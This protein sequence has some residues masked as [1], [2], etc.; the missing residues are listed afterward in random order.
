ML[1]AFSVAGAL[2]PLGIEITPEHPLLLFQAPELRGQDIGPY[3]ATLVQ[4][5]ADLDPALKAY[6][7]LRV[8]PFSETGATEERV[9]ALLAALQEA[10]VPVALEI[11][12][13]GAGPTAGLKAVEK[14]VADFTVVRGLVVQGLTFDEY[15]PVGEAIR[16]EVAPKVAWLTG[17]IDV[18]ARYGRFISI[19][20]EGLHWTRVMANDWCKPL[21]DKIAACAD[22]VIPVAVYRNGHTIAGVSSALGL[23]TEGAVK[24]WGVEAQSKWYAD[25]GFVEPGVFGV[26]EGQPVAPPSALYRAMILNGAMTGATVYS[27]APWT[28]LWFGLDKRHWGEAI[29]PTLTEIIE[30]GFITPEH[31][32]KE[33][34]HVAYQLN[35]AATAE[36]F[37]LNLRDLDPVFDEGFLMRGGYG[38]PHPGQIPELIPDTGRYYWIPILSAHRPE[39]G[40]AFEYTVHPAAMSTPK[41]WRDLLDGYYPPDGEGTACIVRA[42]RGIFIMNTH[43][44]QYGTQNF[45]VANVPAPVRQVQA[46]READ[47]VVLEWPFREGD[48]SYRVHKRTFPAREFHLLGNS[49]DERR[50][51]DVDS[52][53]YETAAYAV[54]ALTNETEPYTGAVN[55]GDYLVIGAV[56]SRIAEEVI[57]SPLTPDAVSRII[58]GDAD[59]RPVEQT[60]WPTLDGL[61]E[62]EAVAA[63]GIVERLD[64]W[65]Q[66]FHKESLDDIMDLYSVNYEDPQGWRAQ[67]VKRA[68]Q[69]FFERYRNGRMHRQIRKW[70]FSAYASGRINVLLYVKCVGIALTDPSGRYADQVAYFPRTGNGEVWVSFVNEDG[71][72]RILGTHPALPNFRDILSW[73]T[74]P[75][76]AYSPG[77]DN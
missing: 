7:V 16:P 44:N 45:T 35:A 13:G 24:R 69:W 70:D 48:V 59:P 14:L 52:D 39:G 67:Y 66:A 2:P 46:R 12:P 9:R 29:H 25:A 10:S 33:K 68:Y 34:I 17:A 20:L 8:S 63:R 55:Y 27:F 77:P 18:A 38:V 65:E 53:P 21:Y 43:E 32:V 30:N 74:G 6:A 37:H 26:A 19:H 4:C 62:T 60:W 56:E 23:W 54:T 61:S 71:A 5:W 49:V 51:V 40:P 42:G 36:A 41:Q 72:W 15:E 47:T 28:D 75:F 50:F 57:V 58:V 11:T 76:D 1:A 64:A 3:A 22:Y 73:S 31:F